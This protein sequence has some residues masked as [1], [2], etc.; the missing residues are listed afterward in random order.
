MKYT[1]KGGKLIKKIGD[2]VI[3]KLEKDGHTIFGGGKLT[4]DDIEPHESMTSYTDCIGRMLTYNAGLQIAHWQANT[5]TNEHRALGDL[6]SALVGLVDDLAEC[7]MGKTT[8]IEFPSDM[9]VKKL[10]KPCAEGLAIVEEM[11]ELCGDD[12]QDLM[13]ILAD[14]QIALNKA[15]YLL[16]EK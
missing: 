6:Y 10:T 4:K 5:I 16:K 14:M 3:D 8:V 7:Y 2:G 12:D 15:K 11:M 1:L 13:N 9:T